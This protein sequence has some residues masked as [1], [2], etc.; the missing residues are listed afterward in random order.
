MLIWSSASSSYS[1]SKL[2][3]FSASTTVNI[4][5]TSINDFNSLST[6]VS[7]TEMG[8]AT[9]LVSSIRYSGRFGPWTSCKVDSTRSSRIEQQTHPFERLTEFPETPATSSASILISPKSL[10]RT[11][12]RRPWFPCSM[13]L[14]SDVFPAPRNPLRIVI[15]TGV[16]GSETSNIFYLVLNLIKY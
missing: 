3:I 7:E 2:R 15:G 16:F 6:K 1:S 8:S 11:P 13:W 10:T 14:S 4:L 9:P 12:I 5:S